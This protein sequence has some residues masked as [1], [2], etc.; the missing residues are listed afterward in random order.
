M[1]LTI[2]RM[3]PKISS[4]ISASSGSTSVTIVRPINLSSLKKLSEIV[5]GDCGLNTV[6]KAAHDKKRYVEK[7]LKNS[8]L[9]ENQSW[10]KVM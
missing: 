3:G 2:G 9:F 8:E 5:K 6:L 4:C 10:S 7:I 1:T